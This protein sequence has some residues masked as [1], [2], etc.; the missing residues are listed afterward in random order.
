M[1]ELHRLEDV[2]NETNDKIKLEV[3]SAYIDL[4]AEEDNINIIS[5]AVSQAEEDYNLAQVR[6]VAGI[7]TNLAVMDAQEK[8]TQARIT[9]YTSLFKYCT[10][11]AALDKAMGVPVELNSPRYVLDDDKK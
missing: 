8:F 10:T 4:M 11:K 7:G 2:A 1:A 5:S 3:H 6:Y 9:Y